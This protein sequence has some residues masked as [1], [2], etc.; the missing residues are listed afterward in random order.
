MA[1]LLHAVA[2]VSDPADS[3]ADFLVAWNLA[4]PDGVVLAV[5]LGAY[6]AGLAR[7]RARGA[8]SGAPSIPAW[9]TLLTLLGFAALGFA[10][11]GPP[12]VFAEDEFFLHMMQ[13]L[14]LTLA[15]APLLLAAN[16]LA[17]YMW[18]L[19]AGARAA[20]ARSLR[21]RGRVHRVLIRFTR[22]KATLPIYIAA[23][24]AWHLPA[25][26]E[27]A[28]HN[29]ALHYLEH[30]TMFVTAT[31]FWW[32]L[33][34]PAPVRSRLA[35]PLRILY[36]LV[37]LTPSAA[38]GAIITLAGHVLYGHYAAT[39]AHWGLTALED[40][41]IGGLIMWVPGNLVFVGVATVIFFKWYDYEEAKPRRPAPARKRF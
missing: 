14:L 38:L 12:D 37:A 9:R 40:Q 6:L 8:R 10:L 11:L 4:S 13:H 2:S 27:A 35:Y 7:L 24:Y 16:P 21:P 36:L 30:L 18:C 28:V 1:P 19:P 33:A 5:L 29:P 25:A 22:P 39:P 32:P 41:S 34:G 20:V 26:Y 3:F 23:I 31:L 15:A 17:A